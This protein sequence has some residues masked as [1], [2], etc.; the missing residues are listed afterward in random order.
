MSDSR[1]DLDIYFVIPDIRGIFR[2]DAIHIPR[3]L[4]QQLRQDQFEITVN[5]AF[6]T[7]IEKCATITKQRP[8][9]WIS[10]PIINLYCNLHRDGFAHSVEVWDGDDL[11]GGIY[12]V[13]L[14]SVFFGESMFSSRPNTSKIAFMHLLAR[15]IRSGFLILDAQLSSPH[16]EQFGLLHVSNE[17]FEV[18]LAELLKHD[19]DFG[20]NKPISGAEVVEIIESAKY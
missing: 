19:R 20:E 17:Q 5:E 7:V 14:G 9:T 11:V 12:G 3:R 4:K 16:L 6:P 18:I 8:E 2:L 13:A 1:F 15:L 10:S